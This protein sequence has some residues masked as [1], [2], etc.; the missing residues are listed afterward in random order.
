MDIKTLL[1]DLREETF[2]SVCMCKFTD[3]KQLPCLHSFCLH[4]LNEI[5]RTSGCRDIACPLCR[6]EFRVPEDGN[7]A[8]PANFRINRLLDILAIT[9]CNK[10]GVKCGNCDKKSEHCF[11]CFQCS[12]FWCN[13]CVGLHNGIKANKDHRVLALKD[14]Q[15]QDFES[16]L[17]QPAVC[18]KQGHEN[19]KL[20]FFCKRCKVAICYS[21]IATVHEGHPK[22]L[23]DEAANERKL[24]VQTAIECQK[25]RALEKKQKIDRIQASC[26]N[27][28]A[29]VDGFKK[30]AE[31]FV[32]SIMAALE[33]KKQELFNDVKKEANDILQRLE[34]K[35]GKLESEVIKIETAIKET[36]KILKRRINGEITKLNT[37]TIFE[38]DSDTTYDYSTRT[39]I[40]REQVNCDAEVLRH[41]FFVQNETLMDIVNSR[42]MGSFRSF[43]AKTVA[44]QSSAEGEGIKEATVGLEAEI[45]LTTRNSSRSQRYERDDYVQVEIRNQDGIK[46]KKDYFTKDKAAF[47]HGSGFSDKDVFPVV[48]TKAIVTDNQNGTYKISYFAPE[49][50]T[51]EASVKVNGQHVCG[52]PFTVQVKA[53]QYKP[54]LSFNGQGYFFG[55]FNGPWGVAVNRQNEV[56]VTELMNHRVQIFS[57]DG[58]FVR[59]FGS[60]GVKKGQFDGPSGIAFHNDNIV[61]VDCH[62]HRL[63]VFCGHGEFLYQFWG[64]LKYPRGLS[65]NPDGNL[66]VSDTGNKSVK[67]FSPKGYLLRTIFISTASSLHCIQTDNFLILSDNKENCVKVFNVEG[68]FLYKFG[69]EGSGNQEF[70]YPSCLFVDKVGNIV[71][72]DYSNHRLQVLERS[73]KFVTTLGTV[74]ELSGPNSAAILSD[75]KIVVTDLVGNCVHVFE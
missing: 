17:N 30:D 10:S 8:L 37:D 47:K 11:Y 25:K 36:E 12:G 32:D 24:R 67:V 66:I 62:N 6:R 54:V 71:V 34:S 44:Q 42:G 70:F 65:V 13:N 19:K 16:I 39:Y 63:Q 55:R 15:Y 5:Q 75:G 68:M 35:Q 3:P 29:Q 49:T 60:K 61:V 22:I 41:F 38:R 64:R 58:T 20:E 28:Q 50:G 7:Q 53:R 52:S 27:I 1:D 57:S 59:S 74:K 18:E 33:A 40:D 26:R 31:M 14:F 23:L 2:C 56:A 45:L 21:C 73:G 9:E 43:L 72:C 4:C 46:L 48:A 51:C 69:K